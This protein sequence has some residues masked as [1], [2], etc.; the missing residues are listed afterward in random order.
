VQA[1]GLRRHV[2]R[3]HFRAL[4]QISVLASIIRAWAGDQGHG[5]WSDLP[6]TG[7]VGDVAKE[8]NDGLQFSLVWDLG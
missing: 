7:G 4:K 2:T 6:G 5:G 1:A 8:D 3:Y